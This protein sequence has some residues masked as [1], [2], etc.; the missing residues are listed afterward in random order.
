M[1]FKLH[2][3][4]AL[5]ILPAQIVARTHCPPLGPVLPAP[6]CPSKSDGVKSAITTLADS[7]AALTGGLNMSAVSV[8][9]KSIHESEPMFDFH[10]TPPKLSPNGTQKVDANTIYRIGSISKV[11]TVLGVLML[12]GVHFD[13]PVTKYLPELRA[14]RPEV[15][16]VNAITTPDWDA[17]TSGSLAS[18]M[19][20]I[21][22]DGNF[23]QLRPF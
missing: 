3:A 13:D 2:A 12:E 15:G 20:G 23:D 7:L 18:H 17:I 10:H 1:K 4:I 14:L 5:A 9:V 21:A 22:G 8:S 19:S 11:F 6:V 16:E